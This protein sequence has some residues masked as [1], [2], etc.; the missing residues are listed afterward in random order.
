MPA[1]NCG[2][3][4]WDSPRSGNVRVHGAP[5]LAEIHLSPP[6][7]GENTIVSSGPHVPPRWLRTSHKT[8]GAASSRR[9]RERA[10]RPFRSRRFNFRSAKNPIEALSGDQNGEMPPSVPG[11]CQTSSETSDR[12]HSAVTSPARPLK[13]RSRPSGDMARMVF[14][15][16]ET[17]AGAHRTPSG[18]LIDTLT[19]SGAGDR[20]GATSGRDR[21]APNLWSLSR[22]RTLRERCRRR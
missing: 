21:V 20:S 1:R 22:S 7:N 14:G 5:P 3:T 8:V 11:S 16:P 13:T 9:S 6:E 15:T 17:T 18:R 19:G 10:P 4:C 2:R 12:S